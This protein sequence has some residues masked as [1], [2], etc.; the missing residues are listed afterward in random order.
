MTKS[1]KSGPDLIE[2][3]ENQQKRTK[4]YQKLS[5]LI[6]KVNIN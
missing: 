3:F 5:N 4:I 1:I 6:D 2:K